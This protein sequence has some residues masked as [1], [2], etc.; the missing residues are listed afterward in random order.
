MKRIIN[1][2][3][4]IALLPALNSCY[5]FV[6]IEG[7]TTGD[8]EIYAFTADKYTLES[9]GTD[10]VTFSL[11]D[12]ETGL[13]LTET[14]LSK[15]YF[16]N[17]TT[18][19]TLPR[20]TRT[21][22]SITDGT[23]EFE[24][25]F[26]SAV[27]EQTVTVIS[28]NRSRYEKYHKNVAVIKITS[29]S[30]SACPDWGVRYSKISD[31][32]KEHAILMEC[33]GNFQRQDK[34]SLQLNGKDLAVVLGVNFWPAASLTWPSSI[35]DMRSGLISG[36]TSAIEDKIKEQLWDNPATCGMKISSSLS[37]NELKIDVT[38]CSEKDGSYDIAYVVL[39]D[40]EY[41]SDAAFAP[42]D[43]TFSEIIYAC[44][45]NISGYQKSSA[46]EATA[47]KEVK[48]SYTFS[49]PAFEA[50]KKNLR[51]VALAM[52]KGDDGKSFI[53]NTVECPAG[54]SADYLYN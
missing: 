53:D 31:Y 35:Y 42:E 13:D 20:G 49:N 29:E 7:G 3:A 45:E 51:V 38:F 21:F 44:S 5:D 41:Y 8:D 23:Y 33:H 48:K 17:L 14:A 12:R 10:V 16:K 24:A 32:H 15:V 36:G 40:N 6:K 27:C 52:R 19:E 54:A 30:C 2:F 43:K 47:G 39:L 1:I 34:Y 9:D 50:K 46:F 11:I 18:G 4:A 22:S 28:H 25:S 26:G 37:S